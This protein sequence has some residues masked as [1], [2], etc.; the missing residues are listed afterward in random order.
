M[1]QIRGQL[2]LW[3]TKLYFVALSSSDSEGLALLLS[4]Y[5]SKYTSHVF[6]FNSIPPKNQRKFDDKDLN[7]TSYLYVQK[8]YGNLASKMS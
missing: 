8:S 4:K 1:K 3:L 6:V 5:L 7:F 2:N